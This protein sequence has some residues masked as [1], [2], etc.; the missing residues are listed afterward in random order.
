M[1]YAYKER[2]KLGNYQT[3][4]GT[5]YIVHP[6]SRLMGVVKKCW[7]E[8]ENLEAAL[9]AMKLSPVAEEQAPC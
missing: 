4:A 8:Y 9:E 5:R 3:A 2:N 6:A 1:I 7:K